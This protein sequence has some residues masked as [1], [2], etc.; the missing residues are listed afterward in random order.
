MYLHIL[1]DSDQG[2]RASF[3]L[4]GQTNAQLYPE[5]LEQRRT[6]GL[7]HDKDVR[8]SSAISSDIRGSQNIGDDQDRIKTT[9]DAVS[10]HVVRFYNFIWQSF[11]KEIW[12]QH[13]ESLMSL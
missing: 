12:M 9:I 13:V 7:G 5:D 6:T 3:L 11:F 10:R 1:L 4:Q 2:F 8:V